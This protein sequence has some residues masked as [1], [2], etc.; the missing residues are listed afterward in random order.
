MKNFEERLQELEEVGE[1]IREGKISLDEAV[2]EF[3][4]GIRLAKGLEKDL[5][6]I[7]RKVEVLVN[8]PDEP[9]E[10][11]VLELF[12]ELSQAAGGPAEPEPNDTNT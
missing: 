4:R 6:R 5:A 12:P 9:G 2:K 3:E 8:E 7:E 1:R 10:K 11:P